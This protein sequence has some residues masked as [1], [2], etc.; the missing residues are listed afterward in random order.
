MR[1]NGPGRE[2]DRRESEE[3]PVSSPPIA[4]SWPAEAA[5]R[6]LD[7]AAT[8]VHEAEAASAAQARAERILAESLPRYWAEF[9]HEAEASVAAFNEAL[10]GRRSALRTTD[11]APAV[12]IAGP[13]EASHLV[14]L[15]SE[16]V[17]ALCVSHRDRDR[18]RSLSW[19]RELMAHPTEDR[20]EPTPRAA[21]RE[22]LE[23]FLASVL[24][25]PVAAPEA[26][27]PG[28]ASTVGGWMGRI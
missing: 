5:I 15:F 25:E 2:T 4:P 9:V 21:V 1:K 16:A 24:I 28:R 14:V 17:A 12:W 20:L 3:T 22:L 8:A 6:V 18:G 11:P 13:G 10:A 7:G 26:E 27:A 19:W 23:P